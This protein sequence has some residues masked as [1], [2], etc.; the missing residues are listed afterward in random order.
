M[1]GIGKVGEA[2]TWTCLRLWKRK[3]PASQHENTSPLPVL[4]DG[5][6]VARETSLVRAYER[7]RQRL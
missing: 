1:G 3:E 4:A 5:L 7:R 2:D 6:H